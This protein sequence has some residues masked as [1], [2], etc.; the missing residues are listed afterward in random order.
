[1]VFLL[2]LILL[3]GGLFFLWF[4]GQ[5][6]LAR[7]SATVAS[8]PF[9]LQTRSDTDGDGL[10]DWEEALWR[11]DLLNPDT[12]GD[13]LADGAE[14]AGGRNP[15][16]AGQEL[17]TGSWSDNLKQENEQNATILGAALK[18]RQTPLLIE[19]P[20]NLAKPSF[21]YSD[22]DLKITTDN[23]VTAQIYATNFKSFANAL[24]GQTMTNP[25]A[26]VLDYSE[27]RDPAAVSNLKN[28]RT[29][30]Q[31]QLQKQLQ[32]LVPREALAAHLAL[33]NSLD[34]L[35]QNLEAMS[36]VASEPILALQATQ[37][38]TDQVYDLVRAIKKLDQYFYEQKID[39][40]N[41][42]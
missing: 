37:A 40:A 22:N 38:Y 20:T 33:V 27:K 11:S 34:S 8:T 26:L 42:G 32:T 5:Q 4:L 6:S 25:V 24:Q 15:V 29:F 30:Y 10:L 12:D 2:M 35:A 19:N 28:M 1:M 18:N 7:Q 3:G 31:G 36:Q 16:L 13:R 14:V 17:S 21:H 9:Y 39:L 41:H 23:K